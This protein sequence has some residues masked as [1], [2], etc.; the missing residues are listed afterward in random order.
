MKKPP[1]KYFCIKCG[2]ECEINPRHERFDTKTGKPVFSYWATCPA[3]PRGWWV[4]NDG[5]ADEVWVGG[6]DS[7]PYPP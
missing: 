7:T 6:F 2:R 1:K 4:V 5:H 3:V